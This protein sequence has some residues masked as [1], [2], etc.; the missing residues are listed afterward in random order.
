M[1]AM[2]LPDYVRKAMDR[3]EQ[4]GFEV[5]VV[6][7]A[8]RDWL[9]GLEPHDFDLATSAKPEQTAA[10]FDKCALTG[11]KHGTVTAIIDHHPVEITTFRKDGDYA[12]HRKPRHVEFID[13]IHQDLARRDFTINAM[14]WNPKTGLIDPFHG[15]EDLEKGVIRAVGDPEV[16]FEEDALRMIRAWRFAARLNFKLDEKTEEAIAHKE[17][18][19]A[20]VAPERIVPEIEE[21]MKD[22]PQV[23][24]HM[25]G[26]L[27]PW[28]PELE[29][30]KNTEQNSPY[31][32]TDVLH[33]TLDA[34]KGMD[35]WDPDVAWA[36]LLHDSGKPACKTTDAR[37]VDHFKKHPQ[38][39]EKIARRVMRD[40]KMDNHKRKVVPWLVLYHDSYLSPKLAN[41]Y[42]LLIERGW[43]DATMQKYFAVQKGDI[44]AHSKIER[45]S[46]MEAFKKFYEEES[47]KRPLSTKD[48][49]LRGGEIA[50]LGNLCG[51]QISLAQKKLL[52]KAFYHPE[53]NRPQNL[54][55]TLAGMLAD[56][57]RQAP[58][59]CLNRKNEQK[60][61]G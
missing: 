46:Q 3:L 29:I 21:I 10:L 38:E 60:K 1:E 12:G 33:H 32:Y 58:V 49:A 37:G 19:I 48:L 47:K 51:P 5:Y 34:L 41:L 8:V 42:K 25:T 13:D 17:P 30:M 61:Q 24:E 31:H 54:A 43:D 26:L 7:G 57:R 55:R 36:L 15:K 2:K 4:A 39:S 59:A 52:E 11:M 35:H 50:R 14:A 56:I 27:K 18:L 28:I 44:L 53:L 40:M 6:G 9:R 23:L 45:L 16:R 20:D 22:N